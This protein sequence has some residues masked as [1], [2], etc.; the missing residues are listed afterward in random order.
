VRPSAKSGRP[1]FVVVASR[2][3]FDASC[4]PEQSRRTLGRGPQADPKRIFQAPR[5]TIRNTLTGSGM[6]LETAERWCDAW[7]IE[8]AERGLPRDAAHWQAGQEWIAAE[9]NPS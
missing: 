6:S 7:E 5:A 3:T 1:R 2:R 9:R 4:A 8:A